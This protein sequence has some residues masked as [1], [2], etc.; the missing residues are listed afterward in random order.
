MGWLKNKHRRYTPA[1]ATCVAPSTLPWCTNPVSARYSPPSRVYTSKMEQCPTHFPSQIPFP[2]IFLSF[3]SRHTLLTPPP[4][5]PP[6]LRTP[7]CPLPSKVVVVDASVADF[8]RKT[9]FS[10]PPPFPGCP[11]S[12][13]ESRLSC[14]PTRVALVPPPNTRRGCSVSPTA[15][16][17]LHRATPPSRISLLVWGSKVLAALRKRGHP[18]TAGLVLQLADHHARR[19]R[20][21][22]RRTRENTR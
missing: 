10:G 17:S 6:Q 16:H 2:T 22:K 11:V 1:R 15:R 20:Q 21:K 7:P 14:P 5:F 12:E 3:T 9:S 4:P 8:R 19:H 13:H 18:S